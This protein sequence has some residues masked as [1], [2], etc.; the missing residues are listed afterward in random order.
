ML[1]AVTKKQSGLSMKKIH[2]AFFGF[3]HIFCGWIF[4]A[5]VSTP[6]IAQPVDDVRLEYQATGIVATIRLTAP[7]QYLRHFPKSH[8]KVLEIFYD[9]ISSTTTEEPWIDNEVHKS[10]PSTLI[11]SFTVTTRDQQT[12]PK[13]VIE[14]DHETDYSVASG[15]DA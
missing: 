6:A 14:F 4:L 5:A 15:K 9:K 3:H 8:G 2:H 12:K 10:P 7:V 11:P 13:L 1:W